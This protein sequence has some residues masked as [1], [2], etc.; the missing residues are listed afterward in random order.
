[1]S[2][3][4]LPPFILPSAEVLYVWPLILQ[5]FSTF[6]STNPTHA[7]VKP[8][9][10]HLPKCS[11]RCMTTRVP[12]CPPE[13]TKGPPRSVRRRR[14][15]EQEITITADGGLARG[16]VRKKGSVVVACNL[17][18]LFPRDH[19]RVGRIS[20]IATVDAVMSHFTV[21]LVSLNFLFL[22]GVKRNFRLFVKIIQYYYM[23]SNC[24]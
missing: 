20:S 3:F 13:R 10:S 9:L 5:S 6:T 12:F 8:A 4:G 17:H 1:M 18:S 24:I 7:V 16:P 22:G 21:L 23:S 15:S 2:A 19:G 11:V 14:R